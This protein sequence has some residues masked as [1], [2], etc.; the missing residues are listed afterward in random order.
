ME[1]GYEAH[2]DSVDARS[3]PYTTHSKGL[4]PIRRSLR[5]IRKSTLYRAGLHTYHLLK[6]RKKMSQGLVGLLRDW[7]D[8]RETFIMKK[9]ALIATG[10]A[11]WFAASSIALA[12]PTQPVTIVVPYAAGGAVDLVARATAAAITQELGQPVIVQNRVG[13][14]G[15]VAAAF[16]SRATPDGYTLLMS[17]PALTIAP[18]IFDSL[19]YDP[20]KDLAPIVKIGAAPAVLLA[21]PTSGISSVQDLIDRAKKSP[22]PMRYAH[23]GIG[24]STE[25]LVSEIFLDSAGIKMEGIPYKGGSPAMND[26]IGDRVDVM[27]T[28]LLNAA[29]MVRGGKLKALAIAGPD[30]VE[31]MP[32]V[33]TL[34]ELGYPVNVSVWWGLLG[35]SGMPAEVVQ[36][37]NRATV[38]ALKDGELR[39]RL[40]DMNAIPI[41]GSPEQFAKENQAEFKVW[42]GTIGNLKKQGVLN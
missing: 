37:V 7:P 28:N 23:G 32:G 8:N 12:Y 10:L 16:V 30:R 21:S 15:N 4:P 36:K 5:V 24:T 1:L 11:T 22:Q 29:P 26:L 41:G 6:V 14:G 9:L 27:F 39:Q 25:H 33:P 40:L 18:Y 20:A 13:A 35:P 34:T 42:E 19:Q 38:N 17:G 3:V 2:L 31:A